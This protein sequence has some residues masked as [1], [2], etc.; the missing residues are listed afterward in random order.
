MNW[1]GRL[2]VVACLAASATARADDP[3]DS[4]TWNDDT[5]GS[6]NVLL[7]GT[8]QVH[9]LQAAVAQRDEDWAL[10]DVLAGHSYEARI[11]GS[12]TD[13]SSL[14][15]DSSRTI[16]HR[17]DA[18]G[19]VV[20]DSVC[21]THPI[22]NGLCLERSLRFTGAANSVTYLRVTGTPSATSSYQYSI[23]LF[24]TT[25]AVPR[26]NNSATQITILLVQNTTSAAVAGT[27]YFY[28]GGGAPLAT[29]PLDVP[30]GGVQVLNT[31]SVAA[32]MA[33]SI[34]VAHDGPYGAL[35]GKAVVVEPATGFTF[36][37]TMVPIPQ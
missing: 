33:G 31:T 8:R 17:V 37:T 18:A 36:D 4:S 9:D 11:D 14:D 1:M 15:N 13:I 6:L 19:N 35:A 12:S 30:G 32:G 10:V 2:L 21:L 27:I 25:Y 5:S 23:A 26:F 7:P 28:A 24:D 16:F 29:A 3:W 20:Q 22:S 34:Q